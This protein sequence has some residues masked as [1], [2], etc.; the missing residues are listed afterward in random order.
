MKALAVSAVCLLVLVLIGLVAWG[1]SAWQNQSARNIAVSEQ[2]AA[3]KAVVGQAQAQA[4]T[5]AQQ[6][7]VSGQ[8]RDRLDI[9]VHQDNAQS[10]AA[11]PGADAPLDPALNTAGRR[12]LCRHPAYAADPGCAGLLGAD[13]AVLPPPGPANAAPGS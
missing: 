3:G 7:V 6:I 9:Q 1:V 10:I 4:Q 5:T 12:G 8:A 11:A 13:P 2:T